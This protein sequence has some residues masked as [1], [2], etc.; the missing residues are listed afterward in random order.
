ME[1][2][3]D[4][5]KQQASTTSGSARDGEGVAGPP[6]LAFIGLGAMGEPMA[7]RLAGAGVRLRLYDVRADATRALADELGARAAADARE[8]ADGADGAITMLPDEKVV[9]AV[10]TGGLAEALGPGAVIVDMSSSDPMATRALG[11]E[12]AAARTVLLDAPVSGGTR[13][14]ADGTLAIMLGGDDPAACAKV[15]PW[16]APLGEVYPTGRL[17]SGHAMKALNNFV[18]SAG[19]AA[20]CEALI[21]GEAF[22]LA[23]QTIVDVLNAST[24]RNNATMVKLEPFVLPRTYASG[25]AMALMAKDVGLARR[26]ADELQIPA[27]TLVAMDTLWRAAAEASGPDADHTAVHRFLSVAPDEG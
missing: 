1:S 26:L 27:P 13:R 25:F 16:L 3:D 21:L 12:L 8:A 7:R 6:T 17:G 20:A 5:T 19:L 22:G 15:R 2:A 14:A 10:V 9:R 4:G 24:G 18:S 23:P 11:A